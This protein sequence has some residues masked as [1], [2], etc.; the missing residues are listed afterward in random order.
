MVNIILSGVLVGAVAWIVA[1]GVG[2]ITKNQLKTTQNTPKCKEIKKDDKVIVN[3]QS[4]ALDGEEMAKTAKRAIK[5]KAKG[6]QSN[7]KAVVNMD[8]GR[9]FE[10]AQ[11]AAN[12]YKCDSSSILKCCK[13]KQRRCHGMHWAYVNTIKSNKK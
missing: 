3:R 4:S 13:G 6:V 11:E 1:R 10:S 9:V 8:T 2:S 7:K 12:F 5:K